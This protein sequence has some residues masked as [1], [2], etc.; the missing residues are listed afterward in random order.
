MALIG[1][2]IHQIIVMQHV[3]SFV[4]ENNYLIILY[5]LA[6][7]PKLSPYA[8]SFGDQR[9]RI[10]EMFLFCLLSI[11][12]YLAPVQQAPSIFGGWQHR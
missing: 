9:K 3:C 8:P 4:F 6:H 10:F 12:S 1:L 11:I 5:Y 7:A 2:P